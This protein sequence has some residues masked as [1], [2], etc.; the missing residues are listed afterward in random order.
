[1]LAP[2]NRSMGLTVMLIAVA[3]LIIAFIVLVRARNV[4]QPQPANQPLRPQERLNMP[5]ATT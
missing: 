1:M 5:S 2:G 3:I 4:H